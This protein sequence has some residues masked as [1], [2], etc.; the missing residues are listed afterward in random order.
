MVGEFELGAWSNVTTDQ[1]IADV[2]P[3]V[4]L[5]IGVVAPVIAKGCFPIGRKVKYDLE[6]LLLVAGLA[7]P[8]VGHT[9]ADSPL[10]DEMLDVG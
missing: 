5:W 4:V 2:A 6:A 7:V 3:R 1:R 10:F 8:P 9:I